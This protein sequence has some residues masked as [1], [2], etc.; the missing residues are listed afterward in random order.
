[1]SS[2]GLRERPEARWALWSGIAGALAATALSVKGI[3]ASGSSTAALG[4]IAVPLVAVLGAIPVGLWGAALGH[5]VLRRRGV[6]QSGATVFFAALAIAA[7]LPA[8]VIYEIQ[9][10]LRLEAAVREVLAMDVAELDRAYR[11]SPWKRDRYFLAAMAQIAR[12]ENVQLTQI[13]YK[14]GSQVEIALLGGH[15]DLGASEFSASQIDAGQI[16]LLLLFREERSSEYP[17]I[18]VLKE[19]GYG[20]IDAPMFMNV[21]GPAGLPPAIA[22]KLEDAFTNATKEP[23]FVKGIKEIRWSNIHRNSKELT[24]YIARSYENYGK[25]MKELGLAK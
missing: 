6:V 24:E 4:F 23:A 2:N 10:G 12:R 22:R 13:P 17:Q 18:P 21:A 15:I 14:G 20:D 5:V 3:F 16:R 19:Y 25:L 9:H 1:V 7:A 11:E 8:A